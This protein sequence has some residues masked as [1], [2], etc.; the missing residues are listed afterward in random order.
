MPIFMMH[1]R[2]WL[3]QDASWCILIVNVLKDVQIQL[4]C[5]D[6]SSESK[7]SYYEFESKIAYQEQSNGVSKAIRGVSNM[8]NDVRLTN[9]SYTQ[10]ELELVWNCLWYTMRNCIKIV[11]CEDDSIGIVK[12][13]GCC[14]Y[15]WWEE[16]LRFMTIRR[17]IFQTE[18][19]EF[20]SGFTEN[21]E[22]SSGFTEN[23]E[24]S[25]GFIKNCE[26]I[27]FTRCYI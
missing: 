8:N 5:E 9:S 25:S 1:F 26:F 18:S 14:N 27:Q 23:C 20:S 19:Y 4:I 21:C 6:D 2:L 24:F 7:I 12:F 10:T 11:I 13:E 15:N 16:P 17:R 22:S 3:M